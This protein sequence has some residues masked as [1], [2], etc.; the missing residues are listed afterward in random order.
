[1][2]EEDSMMNRVKNV[3]ELESKANLCVDEKLHEVSL[4]NVQPR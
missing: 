3:G 1:M 2:V 4:I